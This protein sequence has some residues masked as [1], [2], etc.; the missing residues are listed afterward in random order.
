MSYKVGIV[1]AATGKCSK[2]LSPLIRSFKAHFLP[3]TTKLFNVFANS[4]FA[5]QHDSDIV[6]FSQHSLGWPYNSLYIFHMTLAMPEKMH[7]EYIVMADVDLEA[8]NDIDER[9]LSDLVATIA[10]F[11]WGLPSVAFPF[12][13]HPGSPAYMHPGFTLLGDFSGAP[14]M[15][16]VP[17]S[18]L[19]LKWQMRYSI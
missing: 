10:P 11:S 15:L 13:R 19:V 5:E 12:D 3:N 9:I 8:V 16:F 1:V 17:C 7:V 2:F 4:Y 14:R 18:S 6:V